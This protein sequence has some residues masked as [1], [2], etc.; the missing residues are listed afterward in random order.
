MIDELKE[1]VTINSITVKG[2]STSGDYANTAA[3]AVAGTW[4]PAA[5]G[6]LP[7]ITLDAPVE[8]AGAALT[9]TT[10]NPVLVIPTTLTAATQTV[11]IVYSVDTYTYGGETFPAQN[12]LTASFDLK[13]GTIDAWE[14]GKKYVYTLK[15]NLTEELEIKFAPTVTDW[16]DG[17]SA[18]LTV[19]VAL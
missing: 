6:N 17:G 13:A 19:D 12:G 3:G 1:K 14:Q 9:T 10:S 8:L 2:V 15:F 4:T 18:D 16:T 5:A 11:D 7:T